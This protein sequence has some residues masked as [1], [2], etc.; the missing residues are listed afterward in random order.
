[1]KQLMEKHTGDEELE[2]PAEFVDSDSDPAWTPAAKVEDGDEA[3]GPVVGRKRVKKIKPANM[4]KR[5]STSSRNLIS[6]AAQGAGIQE[7]D[8]Y[9]SGETI[10]TKKQR[11]ASG[12]FYLH[13]SIDICGLFVSLIKKITLN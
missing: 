12:K 3:L 6:A 5:A 8:G 1:M 2:E 7:I 11:A 13:L 9:S 4:R 10:H